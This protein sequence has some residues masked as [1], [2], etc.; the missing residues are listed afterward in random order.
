[1]SDVTLKIPINSG[2]QVEQNGEYIAVKSTN[3]PLDVHVPGV[4]TMS[5]KSG[6][7]WR[8]SGGFIGFYIENYGAITGDVLLAVGY[9]DYR[10]GLVV[11]S[12]DAINTI[13]NPITT[14]KIIQTVNVKSDVSGLINYHHYKSVG[15]I[16]EIVS[17]AANM[18]GIRVMSGGISSPSTGGNPAIIGNPVSPTLLSDSYNNNMAAI[19]FRLWNASQDAQLVTPFLVPAGLG[20]YHVSQ[21]ASF[22]NLNYEVM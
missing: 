22:I 15:A 1:M 13:T 8:I 6:D 16:T 19:Y 11:G 5:M 17:P 21:A 2:E 7:V 18:N 20:L 4:G 10:P 14:Q 9:G 12:V 3:V